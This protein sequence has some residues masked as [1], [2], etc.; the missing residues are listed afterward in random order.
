MHGAGLTLDRPALEA[1]L[2]PLLK[3][4]RGSAED[5]MNL[6]SDDGQYLFTTK[7]VL[8]LACRKC[9]VSRIHVQMEAKTHP[10][11]PLFPITNGVFAPRWREVSLDGDPLTYSDSQIW[12]A[13]NANRQTLLEYVA[14]ETGQKLKSDRLTVVWARRMT[15]YKRPDL[16]ISDLK[17]IE[18]L[19][20]HSDRPIQFIVAGQAN[21]AD[22]E[23]I[24]MMNR[25]VKAAKSPELAN[26][27]AYLPHYN[28]RTARLLV[29]GADLWLNTPLRG[30][31]ACGTSGMKA[32]L[33]GALQL[34]TS[35]G[36]IDEVDAAPIGWIIPEENAANSLYGLL[37]LQ[38]APLYYGR[39]ENGLPG[40]WIIKMRANI[41]LIE[42]EFTATRMLDDYY[43]QLYAMSK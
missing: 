19:T 12:E 42:D 31:E 3:Q 26:A 20:K 18:A 10:G 35:D 29:Q 11:S 43:G 13:H 4:A 14:A 25:I 33:N 34:S 9:G 24:E 16:L 32:S 8:A 40:D 21:P 39:G 5:L 1:G 6:A 28:P 2:G 36:W 17:R 37:E 22:A 23:G 7:L 30:M 15:A 27:F 41:K 38:A